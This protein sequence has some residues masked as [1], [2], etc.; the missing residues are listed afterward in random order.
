MYWSR[1]V[2]LVKVTKRPEGK[3]MPIQASRTT[4]FST[5]QSLRMLLT[6]EP[7]RSSR[8]CRILRED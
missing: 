8:S 2:I 4:V 7:C 6:Q 3:E 1:L 5:N